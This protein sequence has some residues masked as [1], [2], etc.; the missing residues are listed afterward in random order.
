MR[1]APSH[2]HTHYAV[3]FSEAPASIDFLRRTF[4]SAARIYG[5]VCLLMLLSVCAFLFLWILRES[6]TPQI[7][8][9]SRD[10]Q[11]HTDNVL[12][13]FFLFQPEL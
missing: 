1:V 8:K 6:R 11:M 9:L 4:S 10:S 7:T 13:A 12:C 2:T 3:L 5:W